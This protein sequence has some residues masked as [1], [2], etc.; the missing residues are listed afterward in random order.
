MRFYLTALL[1][2]LIGSLVLAQDYVPGGSGGNGLVGGG[3]DGTG[4]GSGSGSGWGFGTGDGSGAGNGSGLGI[5]VVLM[6]QV[7]TR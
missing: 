3:S 7:I 4:N 1:F 2:V 5:R 6:T